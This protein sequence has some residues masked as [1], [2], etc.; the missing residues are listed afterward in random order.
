MSKLMKKISIILLLILSTSLVNADDT[1]V[2]DY[3]NNQNFTESQKD[4]NLTMQGLFLLYFNAIWEW[5]PES[6]KDIELKFKNINKWTPIHDALQK[7]VYLDLIKNRPIDLQLSKT[8]PQSF[9]AKLIKTNFDLDLKY[10]TSSPIKLRY[11]LDIMSI[12][13]DASNAPDPTWT[14]VTNNY[15]IENISNFPILNDVYQKLKSQHYDS[16]KFKDEEL[17][18][19]AI[20]WMADAA[21]DKYTTYFPPIEAKNF[22]DS[23]NWNFEGIWANVD[24]EKPW[25]FVII[26]PLKGSPA[27]KAWI[28]AW[29]QVTKIDSFE[30]TDKVTLQEAVSKVKW[31]AGTTVTLTILRAGKTLEIKVTRQK[32]NIPNVEYSV[33]PNWDNYFHIST[34]WEWVAKTFSWYVSDLAKSNPAHKT[35]IDLRSNPGWS[36]EE[37]S[38]MLEF[39][40]PKWKS[41]VNIK[42]KN[43]SSD[44]LALW[45]KWF[46]FLNRR[47]IILINKWS[48]SASEIMAWTIKDYMWDDVRIIW[49]QSYGK[50]SVQS[51]DDYSDGSSFK[52]TIAKWFTGKTQTWID[53]AWIKPDIE[54]VFDEA[55]YKNWIDNQL[56]YAKSLGY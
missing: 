27:E 13:K 20:K 18:H 46:S 16:S 23:L 39:F 25:I 53:W 9:F 11:F 49:E 38:D 28:K 15:E 36:L 45:N 14:P 24:M 55:Q 51:L 8:A 41:V 29:D 32:I 48:A 33:L 43:Y 44:T 52:Y 40:V 30:V 2:W 17:I 19:G 7:W 42:Y 37:V 31:P 12:L 35:I 22:T 10:D 26:S 5:I 4:K 21:W 47:V 34:F 1:K 6:Y 50:G 56:E 3:L 54:V